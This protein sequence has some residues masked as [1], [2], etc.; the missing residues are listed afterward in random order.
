MSTEKINTTRYRCKCE[1]RDCSGKGQAWLSEDDR[2]PE[3]CR[4]CGRR[5]WNGELKRAHLV[6]AFGK[7]QRIS[8]W[9]RETGISKALIRFRVLAGWSSEAAV[10]VKP[11]PNREADNASA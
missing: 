1:L 7:T 8:E 9:A 3:R 11:K 6:T 5:T 10:S 2:V 4:W